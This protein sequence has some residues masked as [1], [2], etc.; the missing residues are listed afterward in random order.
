[1]KNDILIIRNFNLG[2]IIVAIPA[3]K[4]I[5]KKFPNR[6]IS[7]LTFNKLHNFDEYLSLINSDKKLLD[8][9]I[10]INFQGLKN[11]Y[12]NYKNFI[13]L[14]KFN[15]IIYLQDEERPLY[16][17]IR[18]YL[19]FNLINKKNNIKLFKNKKY[20]KTRNES[21]FLDQEIEKN[22]DYSNFLKNYHI[23]KKFLILNPK[24]QQ[25]L[26]NIDNY[27]T[28]SFGG[29]SSPT[30]WSLSNWKLL[31]KY[32]SQYSNFKIVLVGNKNDYILSKTLNY[33]TKFNTINLCGKTSIF[34]LCYIIQNSKMHISNDNGTMHLANILRT[35]SVSLFNNHNP[36]GKWESI[37][38]DSIKLT[39]KEGI[40]KI[41]IYKLFKNLKAAKL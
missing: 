20:D 7:L 25:K 33:P 39:N 1:M 30:N 5:K 38:K 36:I 27:I 34:D 37:D 11:I 10:Y 23:K 31:I 32:L 41:N 3:F 17:R 22:L 24:I 18:N 35:K 28:I 29:E 14:K 40:N 8:E 2:D 4:Y 13:L 9:I 19:L 15:E 16:K 6:N 26:R 21:F 12:T